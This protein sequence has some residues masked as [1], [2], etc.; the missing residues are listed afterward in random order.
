MPWWLWIVGGLVIGMLEL[1]LPGYIFLGFAVGAVIVGAMLGFGLLGSNL[2]AL[3][4]VFAL[5]SLLG[6]YVLRRIFGQPQQSV[7][8]WDRDI[9]D[10][11]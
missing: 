8:K 5:A 11:K 2:A 3:L 9:N 6:W 4:L 10:N 7:V 1:M